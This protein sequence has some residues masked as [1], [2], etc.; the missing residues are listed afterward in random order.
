MVAV[1][2]YH[3]PNCS[4]SRKALDILR[5]LGVDFDVVQYLKTP[6]DRGVLENLVRKLEDPPTDL[7]RHDSFFNELGLDASDYTTPRAV[8]DL[9]LEH[10]R[11]MQRPVLVRDGRAII[12]RPLERVAPF[13]K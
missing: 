7:V 1:T 12:G 13:A 2:L 10:P 3:N 5:G 8:V 6:P 4:T 11:L 9:L